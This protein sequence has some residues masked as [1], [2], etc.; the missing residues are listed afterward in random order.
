MA[1]K[2]PSNAQWTDLV[3]KIKAKV[4]ASDILDLLYPVGSYFITSDEDF[5]PEIL[6]GGTWELSG[7][8][9]GGRGAVWSAIGEV[10]DSAGAVWKVDGVI[11]NRWHRIE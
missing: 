3:N 6:W 7:Q 10:W 11:V 9:I 5:D 4:S 2:I 1:N 8:E